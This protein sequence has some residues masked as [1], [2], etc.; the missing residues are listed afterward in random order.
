M[1]RLFFAFAVA[2]ALIGI[3]S[4]RGGSGYND[5]FDH[6][7]GSG[8]HRG[9]SKPD[10]GD[11]GGGDEGGDQG[12][13]SVF[14]GD[15]TYRLMADAVYYGDKNY[16]D[17]DQFNLY[18]YW[19]EYDSNND[20]KADG[21]E[22]V[23]DVLCPKTGKMALSPGKYTCVHDEF[24]PFHF[25]DGY[26]EN[27]EI[28]PSYAYYKSGKESKVVRITDGTMEI[29]TYSGKYNITIVFK[30]EMPGSKTTAQ[31]KVIFDGELPYTDGR[32]SVD[33]DV[34]KSV[35]MKAISKVTAE[36]WGQIWEDNDQKTIPVDD[37]VLYL[38]GE[39]ADNDNEYAT[40]EIFTEPG[41]KALAPGIYN[42]F[43]QLGHIEK[44]KPGA[45]LAGY[46][47]GE[48]N[49]A[50]GTWY[51]KNGTAYYAASKGQLVIAVK[52]DLYSLSF[53]FT[54]EDE[55][56]GG[57]FK[58]S[59]MGKVSIIDK[60]VETKSPVRRGNVMKAIAKTARRLNVKTARQI[61]TD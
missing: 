2:F 1:K 44:F 59:Y 61:S 26:E 36:Y 13:T 22:L 31:Y 40:I 60:T 53:D 57:S 4:C 3:S 17:A 5:P 23:F 27:G 48:D 15:Q 34:P 7:S 21:T 8:H 32:G 25:L 12:S 29:S 47:E 41:A 20:F 37:W 6:H 49:I 58:G 35:E 30:A 54:D 46:I 14:P 45:V 42:D 52:D 28:Y 56:Y 33:R 50:Y 38:Y 51:C 16:P 18:L 43:A 10:G 9:D 39:N 19:G 11:E 24:T 55:V